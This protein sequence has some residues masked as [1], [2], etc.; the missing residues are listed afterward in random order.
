MDLAVSEDRDFGERDRKPDRTRPLLEVPGGLR[1]RARE[2]RHAVDLAHAVARP[3]ARGSGSRSPAGRPTRRSRTGEGA[4]GH[5]LA[6]TPRR[7]RRAPS[8]PSA[9]RR[10]VIGDDPPVIGHDLG[11][12][13]GRGVGRIMVAPV[14]SASQASRRTRLRRGT[15]AARSRPGRQ[16]GRRLRASRPSRRRRCCDG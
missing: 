10:A 1:D 7:R 14:P 13:E 3:D 5:S 9:D 2:L 11:V 4:R 8:A 12:A 6:R 16:A 15:R